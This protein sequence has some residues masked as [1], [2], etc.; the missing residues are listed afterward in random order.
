MKWLTAI[1]LLALC[2]AAGPVAATQQG[3]QAIDQWKEMDNCARKA[4]AAYPDF[5]AQSNAKRDKKLKECLESH[6]LP[7]SGPGLR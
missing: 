1:A 7:P 6:N 2:L 5:T 3:Q 4:Q